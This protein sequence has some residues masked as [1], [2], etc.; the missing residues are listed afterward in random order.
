MKSTVILILA[1]LLVMVEISFSRKTS[2][3]QVPLGISRATS[4]AK[5]IRLAGPRTSPSHRL[6]EQEKL[7]NK[8][9]KQVAWKERMLEE[10]INRQQQK[11]ELAIMSQSTLAGSDDSEEDLDDDEDVNAELPKTIKPRLSADRRI[12]FKRLLKRK[13]TE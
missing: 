2:A 12:L 11:D 4:H 13:T 6:E 8:V 5:Q 3:N 7:K 1:A 9:Y 10:K